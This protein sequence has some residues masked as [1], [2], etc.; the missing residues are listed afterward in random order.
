MDLR[1]AAVDQPI[2]SP[3]PRGGG[4]PGSLAMC[5]VS[6]YTIVAYRERS[7]DLQRDHVAHMITQ[8][9]TFARRYS[10]VTISVIAA[11]ALDQRVDNK[12]QQNISMETRAVNLGCETHTHILLELLTLLKRM[13]R[14]HSCHLTTKPG[15]HYEME[16]ATV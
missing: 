4:T 6:V 13:L 9:V 11:G 10:S 12:C 3:P 14:T 5:M 16:S 8:R 7:H 2:L 1:A 15:N